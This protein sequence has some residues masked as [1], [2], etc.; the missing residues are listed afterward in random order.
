MEASTP[1]KL[2]NQNQS[3]EPQQ[4]PG[5]NIHLRP[6]VCRLGSAARPRASSEMAVAMVCR[7]RCRGGGLGAAGEGWGPAALRATA[8]G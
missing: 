4:L 1:V 6:N 3:A 8:C 2:L 5:R 7:Q